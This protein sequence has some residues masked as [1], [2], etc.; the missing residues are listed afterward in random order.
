MSKGTKQ[1]NCL[2][3]WLEQVE[4]IG[5]VKHITAPVDSDLELGSITYMNGKTVGGPTLLF[6]NIKGYPGGRLLFNP[7]GTSLNRVAISIREELGKTP[8][9]YTKILADKMKKRIPPKFIEAKDAPVNQ[10]IDRDDKV[11]VNKFPAP[12][13]WPRDGGKYIGT[14][15]SVITQDAVSGRVNMG[16]YRQM[17]L[18]DKQVGFYA[19]PGKD[20]VLDRETWWK[21]GKPAPVAAVYGQDPLLFL[22]SATSF[23]KDVSE[24]EFAGGINGAPIEVFKSDVTGLTLPANA[25][26]IIEGFSYPDK[27]CEEG[28]FGEFTGYYGRPGGATPYI[29]IK[30]IRYRNKPI[31]TSAL[32]ADYPSNE[33]GTMWAMA[34]AAKIWNDL[35]ALGVPGIKGV[36]SPPEAAGWGMTVVSIE[37]RYAGHAA[38][39]MALAA[40]CMGGAYFTKYVVVVDDD[41]D[42]TNLAEVI[43]AMVTRSRPAQ[44][45]EILRE[46]WSTYLD[47]SLNPP[48]I[49]PW[50]SKCLINACKEFKNLKVF[51]PRNLLKKEMYEQVCARWAELGFEG[52]PPVITTFEP[53]KDAHIG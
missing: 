31:V 51:S 13:M 42:P 35:D 50:G 2:G 41:V 38:Q 21:Q 1:I 48:E 29:D 9:E 7:Y 46:T 11:N 43:W 12:T 26:I 5:E 15:D 53:F 39:T 6:E 45:I 28:P 16:T 20:A 34:K 4:K 17:I 23:P 10:N 52:K 3:D 32:M 14:A 47:P 36:W 18:N 44:S 19:S 27:T 24:Y 37:Q 25:E 30:C 8:I 49:R 40:Q 22:T 33:C